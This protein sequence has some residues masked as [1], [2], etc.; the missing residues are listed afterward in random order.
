M[1]ISQTGS[2]DCV[3]VWAC[4]ATGCYLVH[5]CLPLNPRDNSD[6]MNKEMGEKKMARP[7]VQTHIFK[8]VTRQDCIATLLPPLSFFSWISTE[9]SVSRHP[10]IPHPCI[11]LYIPLLLVEVIGM[12]ALNL[13]LHPLPIPFSFSH[14][15]SGQL[16]RTGASSISERSLL[17]T[18]KH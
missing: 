2:G 17:H 4:V 10:Y 9:G 16:C 5:S 8:K 3:W 14:S 12:L 1:S 18:H 7:H 13:A 11:H 6:L 15:L